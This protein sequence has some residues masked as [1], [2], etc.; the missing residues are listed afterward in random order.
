MY[1]YGERLRSGARPTHRH[2][3]SIFHVRGVMVAS[4]A[5]PSADG[6]SAAAVAGAVVAAVGSRPMRADDLSGQPATLC[7]L[8]QI[9]VAWRSLTGRRQLRQTISG[10]V[11]ILPPARPDAE[12]EVGDGGAEVCVSNGDVSLWC[13]SLF[14]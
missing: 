2:S 11:S 1:V 7:A 3:P 13:Q 6:L 10:E 9:F 5:G 4:S 8:K 12:G 14:T